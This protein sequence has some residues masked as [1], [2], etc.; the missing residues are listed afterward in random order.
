ML[1]F[2]ALFSIQLIYVRCL[3]GVNL[4]SKLKQ[5]RNHNFDAKYMNY[6]YLIVTILVGSPR[7]YMGTIYALI[8][9]F[10]TN[11]SEFMCKIFTVYRP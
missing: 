9:Y 4:L 2:K 10:P 8:P 1:T 11:C 5:H 7:S 3:P 6:G